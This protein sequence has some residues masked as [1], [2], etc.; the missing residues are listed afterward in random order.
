MVIIQYQKSNPAMLPKIKNLLNKLALTRET[1]WNIHE[2]VGEFLNLLII[3]QKYKTV[4]EIGTSNGYSGIWLAEALSQ[5]AKTSKTKSP[6]LYTIESNLKKRFPLAT[7]NFKKA[8]LSKYI[9]QILGHAPEVIPK[10]PHKFNLAFFDATKYEHILYWNAVKHRINKGGTIIVDNITS[11]KE[12]LK[13][14]TK[15]V[16]KDKSFTTITL[17]LGTGLLIAVKN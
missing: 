7:E 8:G 5:V 12:A 9:T 11:H 17:P 13:N 16:Q 15:E 4:L 6:H 2:E 1:F 3:S 10:T 14:F